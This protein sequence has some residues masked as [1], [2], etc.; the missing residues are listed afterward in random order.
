MLGFLIFWETWIPGRAS[1]K[2]ETP[3]RM[4]CP[5]LS[6][7]PTALKPSALV[8]PPLSVNPSRR[9]E[10]QNKGFLEE[11]RSAFACGADPAPLGY[12]KPR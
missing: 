2:G 4:F 8:P 11:S 6:L 3:N 9:E 12:E 1:H 5:A 10:K 7:C